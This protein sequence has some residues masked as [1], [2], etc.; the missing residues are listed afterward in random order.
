LNGMILV[1]INEFQTSTGEG[2]FTLWEW[3][4]WIGN[5]ACV[6]AEFVRQ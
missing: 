1:G 2:R 3:K 6:A 5:N 4:S